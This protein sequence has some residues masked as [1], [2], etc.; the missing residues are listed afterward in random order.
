M[1]CFVIAVLALRAATDFDVY[2]D[3]R[4]TLALQIGDVIYTAEFSPHELNPD[5]IHEGEQ[6]RAEV[7]HGRM[8][9]QLKNGKRAT[10]RIIRVQRTL[11][12]PLP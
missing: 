1:R 7:K 12:H 11:V 9:V 3:S 10:A 2:V 8:T 6:V 4:V 5:S